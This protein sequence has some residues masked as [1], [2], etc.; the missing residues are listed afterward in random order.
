MDFL[1]SFSADSTELDY[2]LVSSLLANAFFSTFPRRTH[3]THPTL[4]NFNFA[5]FFKNLNS[6]CQYSKLRSVLHYFEL[7]ENNN[8]NSDGIL[9]VSRQVSTTECFIYW[10]VWKKWQSLLQ[11]RMYAN[12]TFRYLSTKQQIINNN[13]TLSEKWNKNCCTGLSIKNYH[14]K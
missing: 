13:T 5:D 9:R 14:V 12:I 4:Q 6:N 3:K 8:E 1:I 10:T 2:T 7:L 11:R